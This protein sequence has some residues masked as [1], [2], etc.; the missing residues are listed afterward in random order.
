M[1]SGDNLSPVKE[2]QP[3]AAVY[4]IPTA[5][6]E[7]DDDDDVVNAATATDNAVA[8]TADDDDDADNA[9]DDPSKMDTIRG[10][11]HFLYCVVHTICFVLIYCNYS[12]VHVVAS[13]SKLTIPAIIITVIII[14]VATVVIYSIVQVKNF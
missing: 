7:D 2:V 12:T 4:A 1:L 6:D 13:S 3:T 9:I 10:W 5:A 14:Y 11:V 8:T